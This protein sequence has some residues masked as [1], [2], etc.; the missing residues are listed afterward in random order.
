[1]DTVTYESVLA[2][3]GDWHDYP[4]FF[5]HDKEQE[6]GPYDTTVPNRGDGARFY[7][8]VLVHV[9]KHLPYDLLL[10]VKRRAHEATT[11][12]HYTKHISSLRSRSK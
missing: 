1:M 9:C 6:E 11:Q 4:P 2:A 10:V 7:G 8:R 5:C 12:T 3:L